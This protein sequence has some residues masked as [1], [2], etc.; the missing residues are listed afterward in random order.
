MFK[1][2]MLFPFWLKKTPTPLALVSMKGKILVAWFRRDSCNRL[3]LV[4]VPFGQYFKM[5]FVTSSVVPFEV[6]HTL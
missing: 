6:V 2:R 4:Y 5:L 3:T 1:R